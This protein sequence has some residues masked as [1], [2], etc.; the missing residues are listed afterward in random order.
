MVV[1]CWNRKE[2]KIIGIAVYDYYHY[3]NGDVVGIGI[4][5]DGTINVYKQACYISG[6]TA[7]AYTAEGYS[8]EPVIIGY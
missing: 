4:N 5:S 3:A 7:S 6:G 1:P 2:D 8:S